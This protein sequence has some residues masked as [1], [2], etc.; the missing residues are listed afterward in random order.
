MDIYSCLWNIK[1]YKIQFSSS[2]IVH[3]FVKILFAT[4]RTKYKQIFL[5]PYL[6]VPNLD[7]NNG[8]SGVFCKKGKDTHLTIKP[9]HSILKNK[10]VRYLIIFKYFDIF[11]Y[12]A[13]SEWEFAESFSTYRKS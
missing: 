6:S 4:V 1:N 3:L 9:I 12:F 10:M 13:Q 5:A 2:R 11:I 8:K 7:K